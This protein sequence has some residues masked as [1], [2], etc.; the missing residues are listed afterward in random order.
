MKEIKIFFI[1]F[2]MLIVVFIMVYCDFNKVGNKMVCAGVVKDV[3]YMNVEEIKG[4]TYHIRTV[5]SLPTRVY[6]QAQ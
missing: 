3:Q 2:V 6:F 1:F 5:I 4:A